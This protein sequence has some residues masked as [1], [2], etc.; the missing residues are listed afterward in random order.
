M[1]SDGTYNDIMDKWL[2]KDATKTSGKATGNANEKATPVKPSYK[3][4]SDSSFAPF[5]YQNGKGKYTGFDMELITK[6]AKQQG[7]KLDISNPGFDAA[8]N[9][10]QSG[11]ADGVIAGAT[12]TEARQKSLIFL[13]LI[14]HLALS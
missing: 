9:A 3:I 7:F 1:K 8:L 6:I 13:I 5:E 14:T 4:V 10:V 2:G 11:Q 12:I